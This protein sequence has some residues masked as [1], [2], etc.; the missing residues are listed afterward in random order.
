[1]VLI[2]Q[3]TGISPEWPLPSSSEWICSEWNREWIILSS[4]VSV[5]KKQIF[6]KW[7]GMHSGPDFQCNDLYWEL[8]S[9]LG[10]IITD[11][12]EEESEE[13]LA[14][15]GLAG[16]CWLFM[17]YKRK[18]FHSFDRG[19]PPSGCCCLSTEHGP[20]D[21]GGQGELEAG[22]NWL[23]HKI[24]IEYIYLIWSEQNNE[25]DA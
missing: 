11:N 13:M 6:L 2:Q 8:F 5:N 4:W 15:G 10:R 19:R 12:K 9:A 22:R 23:Q 1:M 21:W 16:C 3:T 14:P 25:H 7:S 24:E 18:V 17:W 20:G